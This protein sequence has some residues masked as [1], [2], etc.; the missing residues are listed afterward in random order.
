[1]LGPVSS[2]ANCGESARKRVASDVEDWFCHHVEGG[3][4]FG[5]RNGHDSGTY[6]RRMHSLTWPLSQGAVPADERADYE[7]KAADAAPHTF[8]N[9]E[10][11][12]VVARKGCI[13]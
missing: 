1:M 5:R 6:R 3:F 13:S 7:R 12:I 8:A 9:S 11:L 4:A 10:N 2:C